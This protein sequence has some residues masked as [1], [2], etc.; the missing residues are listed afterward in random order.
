MPV[1]MPAGQLGAGEFVEPET[2]RVEV[3]DPQ[4]GGEEEDDGKEDATAE[5]FFHLLLSSFVAC[6]AAGFGGGTF[7]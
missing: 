4:T 5:S 2:L 7:P 3:I 1:S 6:Y